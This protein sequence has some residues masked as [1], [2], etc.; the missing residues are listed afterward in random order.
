MSKSDHP[1]FETIGLDGIQ[2][3]L[4]QTGVSFAVLFGSH[5]DG[6]QMSHRMSIS[7]FGS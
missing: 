1:S 4:N 3:Y 5:A 7:H 6:W 2:T